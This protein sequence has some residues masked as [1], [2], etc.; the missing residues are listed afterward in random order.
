MSS[1]HGSGSSDLA[2]PRYYRTLSGSP[3]TVPIPKYS[4]LLSLLLYLYRIW[5]VSANNTKHYSEPISRIYQALISYSIQRTVPTYDTQPTV[6]DLSYTTY[7]THLPYPAYRTNSTVP[8]LRYT[9]YRTNCTVPN[10]PCISASLLAFLC[11]WP[12]LAQWMT[13]AM[14]PLLSTR[15]T[16]AYYGYCSYRFRRYRSIARARTR[17]SRW[18]S[19]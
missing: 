8:H 11:T 1:L 5:V 9:M 18:N 4:S 12:P 17:I 3:S 14:A 10:P 6:P 2:T 13:I 19:A 16:V 7:H 15:Y